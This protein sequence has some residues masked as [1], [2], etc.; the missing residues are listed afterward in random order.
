MQDFD[1]F[2]RFYDLD[3]A[4]IEAD[5]DFWVQLARRTGGPVLEVGCGTGRV[6]LAL[7]T[8]GLSATGVD[9]SPAMLAVA[10]EKV[11][12]AG[13][14]SRVELIQA[15]A[16]ELRLN[17]TFPLAIVALNSFGHFVEPDE[18]ERAL[19]RIREHLEP[20]GIVALDLTNPTP[21]A[22]G[23]TGGLVI[24]EYTR[25]GPTASWQ[26]LKLRSQWQSHL[27]QRIDVSCIYDEISPAGEVRRTLASFALRYFYLNELR[28]LFRV[29]G[30]DL[31]TIY[32]SYDLEP[33]TDDSERLLVI[34]RKPRALP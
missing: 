25:P 20:G 12:A 13:L 23:E 29:V 6:L 21:G 16:L 32:G 14:T 19:V 3:T 27:A 34:G 26:T 4:G 5:L 9:R 24:H 15:N 28:L 1:R 2:A 33:L 18:P 11:A 30:L 17:R 10:R 22:F 31:E 8:A 7:A